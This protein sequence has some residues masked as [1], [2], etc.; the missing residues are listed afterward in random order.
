MKSIQ[1]SHIIC[2][3]LFCLCQ[4]VWMTDPFI[5]APQR[6]NT[7]HSGYHFINWKW[8]KYNSSLTQEHN[9]REYTEADRLYTYL[10]MRERGK[11]RAR[12]IQRQ[13]M[14]TEKTGGEWND[15]AIIFRAIFFSSYKYC[16]LLLQ[17]FYLNHIY[18]S[19]TQINKATGRLQKR[20]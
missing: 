17:R 20:C 2:P 9:T 4:P 13:L 6:K 5:T 10:G 8:E 18:C 16:S 7:C 19:F 12:W 3:P 14:P 11:S 1:W 15:I